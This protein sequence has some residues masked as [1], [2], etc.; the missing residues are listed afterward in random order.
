M[1]NNKDIVK[2]VSKKL[3]LNL[4]VT[5]STICVS[6]RKKM[7]HRCLK[8][9]IVAQRMK[10]KYLLGLSALFHSLLQACTHTRPS[11]V[12]FKYKAKVILLSHQLEETRTLSVSMSTT[13][14][15][16]DSLKVFFIWAEP[17]HLAGAHFCWLQDP[18]PGHEYSSC[19]S[20]CVPFPLMCLTPGTRETLQS[21]C[22]AF[23]SSY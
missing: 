4:V 16:Q 2:K 10:K 19:Y 14:F 3:L 6:S 1:V 13:D 7:Q 11:C 9:L 23:A 12:L 22:G 17:S 8:H 18:H 5:S 20:C 15:P 21:S